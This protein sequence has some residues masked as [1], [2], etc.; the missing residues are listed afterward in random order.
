MQ[1]QKLQGELEKLRRH[2]HPP[3]SDVTE[4]QQ[5]SNPT[6]NTTS[7]NTETPSESTQALASNI[8][9][10]SLGTLRQEDR[11]AHS[12]SLVSIATQTLHRDHDTSDKDHAND[13]STAT[14][15]EEN[16][17]MK[18]EVCIMARPWV[19]FHIDQVMFIASHSSSCKI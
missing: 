17:R 3:G 5:P 7:A 8:G 4:S 19:S 11:A 12:V 1:V 13:S 14:Q 18:E 10:A 15:E 6:A 9:T 2:D 16:F